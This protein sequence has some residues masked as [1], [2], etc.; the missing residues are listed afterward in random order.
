MTAI[1]M[2]SSTKVELS[3]YATK[4]GTAAKLAQPASPGLAQPEPSIRS[5]MMPFHDSPVAHLKRVSSA[6]GS[7]WKPA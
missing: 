5:C 7:E 4:K 1:T 3:V 2:L 6:T